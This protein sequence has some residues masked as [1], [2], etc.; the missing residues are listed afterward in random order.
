[1]EKIIIVG[2]GALGNECLDIII[3]NKKSGMDIECVGFF[4]EKKYNPP[5]YIHKI[6][7]YTCI[8]RIKEIKNAS[9]VVAIGDPNARKRMVL[10]L[11]EN[12]IC[13]FASLIS[14]KSY[15]GMNTNIGVGSIIFGN[16]SISVNTFIGNHVLIN[17]G[18]TIAHD[19]ILHDY[20]TISPGVDTAGHVVINDCAFIGTGASICPKVSIGKRC[21]VGAGA[22]VLKN[23]LDNAVFVGNPARELKK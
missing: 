8:N 1:M 9:F 7:V 18:S 16:T 2:A 20:A 14:C 15:V 3:S 13:N 22:V 23:T 19:N 6:P 4:V 12:Q 21:I 10:F 11:N 17:P 5:N